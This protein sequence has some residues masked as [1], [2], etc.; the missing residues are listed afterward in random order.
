MKRQANNILFVL[1]AIALSSAIRQGANV[2]PVY[3]ERVLNSAISNSYESVKVKEILDKWEEIAFRS[4]W[5][6]I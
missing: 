4:R 3:L 1:L 6:G 5:R 2:K